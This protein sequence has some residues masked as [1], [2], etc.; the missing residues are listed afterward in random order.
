MSTDPLAA[1]QPSAG[2]E[3]AAPVVPETPIIPADP[4]ANQP[5]AEEKAEADEWDAATDKLFPDLKKTDDKENEDEPTK[6]AKKPTEDEADKDPKAPTDVSPDPS[7]PAKTAADAAH[8]DDGTDGEETEQIEPTAAASRLSAREEQQRLDSLKA[9]IRGQLFADIPTEFRAKSEREGMPGELLDSPDKLMQYL[10]PSTGEQF[11]R[12]EAT[13]FLAQAE[14]Q[15]EKNA[16]YVNAQVEQIA[17]VHADL[18]DQ[19]DVINYQYG[20]LFQAMPELRDR[21]LGEYRKSLEIDQ[22]SGLILKA[23]LSLRNFYETALEPYAQLGRQLE[24]QEA[25]TVAAAARTQQQTQAEQQQ[26][27]QQRRQDRSDIYGPG[28]VDTQTDDDKEW[29][30]AAEAVFG[31][32]K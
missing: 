30:A 27:K 18:Q 16:A 21:L 12:D 2:G 8:K 24:A 29:S 23:P 19:A 13:L 20:E 32:L 26:A 9:D 22:K 5:S 3:S 7:K 6:P 1:I 25:Q 4:A 14:R 17:D 31:K 10:N 15:V 28:K 11:T